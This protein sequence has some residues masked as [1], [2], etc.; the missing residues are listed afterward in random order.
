MAM[1]AGL[2][3]D[4]NP[5]A[6]IS[7][8]QSPRFLPKLST[9]AV[10]TLVAFLVFHILVAA[11]SLVI[12][13][14][15]HIG[16][17]KRGPW[18]VRKIYIQADSGEKLFDTPV[19]LVNVGVLMPLWQFL[20]SVTTQAYIWVQ[21]R[22]NLSDEFALHSQFIP[23]LG[24]MVI[25]ETYSQWSMAHCFLVLLYSNK[26]S[27]ITSNSLSWLR[28]PLLVNTFFLVYPLALTAGVIFCVVRMSAA[29]GD[30][31]AHIISIRTILSQGSL[32]WNQLQHA[33]RAG[34]EKSLL[35]SQLSST[36]AQ[37]GTLLQ[38][39]GDILPRI[40]D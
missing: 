28:S 34:E 19:Y 14:L 33:S 8:L 15:P 39:T 5:F 38:E 40:Q 4:A 10:T 32:V 27:T 12:L 9:S 26:T 11:F 23:L 18:L 25:F 13:V 30:L 37:L 21:I 6:F 36:V 24:V 1:L 31:Q 29:Y 16:K 3:A 7:Q 17:G 22:M 2:P 20:G 35:S